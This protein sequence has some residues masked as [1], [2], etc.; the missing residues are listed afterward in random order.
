MARTTIDGYAVVRKGW[1]GRG[2]EVVGLGLDTPSAWRDAAEKLDQGRTDA[3]ECIARHPECKL[4]TTK[5]T[6]TFNRP[7]G[8]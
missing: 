7:E 6:C 5:I 2:M 8:M 3:R 1:L 4:V